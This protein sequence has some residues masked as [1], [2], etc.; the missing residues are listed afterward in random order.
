MALN[1]PMTHW[2]GRRVWLI[3][4]STGIGLATA[5]ALHKQG[6]VVTVSA[7]KAEQ[8]AAFANAHSGARSLPLD[9]TDAKAVA[10]ALASLCVDGVPDCVLYCAGHYRPMG[11]ASIDL[12]EWL[13]HDDVNYRGFLYLLD[14]LLPLWLRTPAS[15]PRHISVIG[16]VAGYRGL[17][18]SLAY[19]P[20]KAALINLAE[21]L[22]LELRPRGIAVSVINPGFV[23]T[24]L[25]QGN[26]FAM[27]ALISTE[28]AAQ[29]ILRGWAQGAFEIHFP[30]RFTWGMQLLR[31]LPYRFYFAITQRLQPRQPDRSAEK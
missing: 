2:Q 17:P 30:R 31:L 7:R 10:Q 1:P 24:P 18:Q 15:T 22:Y 29:A 3:G 11:A 28:Q 8:L 13:R 20:T 5:H 26:D 16:S 4:A 6:A 25:T 23:E 19:G 21:A 14:A 12:A 9:V 27:P